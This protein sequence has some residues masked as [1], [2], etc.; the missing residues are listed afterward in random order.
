LIP[1]GKGYP[2]LATRR[3]LRACVDHQGWSREPPPLF[4]LFDCDPDGINILNTYH[5][6]SKTL[7]QEHAYNLP[8][9]KWLGV[10]LEDEFLNAADD[11]SVQSL[12]ERDRA[13]ARSMLASDDWNGVPDEER[14]RI[15]GCRSALQHMLMLNRKME[16]QVLEER[17]GGTAEWLQRK[18]AQALRH[19][20]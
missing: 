8:E 3:F 12:T 16:I 14:F 4:G 1:Q 11:K 10:K 7:A 18:L 19:Q 13:K 20:T 2:D 17:F 6:G 9:M 15:G 5:F